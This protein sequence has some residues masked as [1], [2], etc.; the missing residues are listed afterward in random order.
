M[1]MELFKRFIIVIQVVFKTHYL[2]KPTWKDFERQLV[3]NVERWPKM[4]ASLD[5]MYFL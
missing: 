4:F 3:I 2:D 5:H 1:A